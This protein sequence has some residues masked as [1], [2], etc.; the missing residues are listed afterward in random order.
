MDKCSLLVQERVSKKEYKANN[1]FIVDC[2]RE[3]KAAADH[4]VKTCKALETKL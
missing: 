4:C 3:A 1:D 2:V